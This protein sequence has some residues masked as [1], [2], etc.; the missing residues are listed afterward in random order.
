MYFYY[1]TLFCQKNQ[2][3]S[4]F[5]SIQVVDKISLAQLTLF[6]GFIPNFKVLIHSIW[7]KSEEN[8]DK[9]LNN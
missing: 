8:V 2:S 1:S 5:F 6:S 3:S 9:S 4:L 7:G